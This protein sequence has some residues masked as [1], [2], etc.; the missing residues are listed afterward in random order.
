MWDLGRA[1]DP[2]PV[3]C[4]RAAT[5]LVGHT[6]PVVA[7]AFAPAPPR[8]LARA[9]DTGEGACNHACNHAVEGEAAD[10]TRSYLAA[11][12]QDGSIRIYLVRALLPHEHRAGVPRSLDPIAVSCPAG[13]GSPLVGRIPTRLIRGRIEL[14]WAGAGIDGGI[15]GGIRGGIRGGILL[16]GYGQQL[17]A[18]RVPDVGTGAAVDEAVGA[19]EE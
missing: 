15:D 6:A 7:L 11:A 14:G 8:A 4:N 12:A 13:P 2:P 1:G 10:C 5:I 17:V 18:C 9:G 16:C 19:T 3:R